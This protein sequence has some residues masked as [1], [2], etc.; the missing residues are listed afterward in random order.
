MPVCFFKLSSYCPN[1]AVRCASMVF[2][3]LRCGL[4]GSLLS[5]A[6]PVFDIATVAEEEEGHAR[7]SPPKS[8]VA[9]ILV[10]A[11]PSVFTIMDGVPCPD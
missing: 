4:P 2:I 7:S 6:A 11:V 8:R 1:L 10:P 9:V 5:A 3:F